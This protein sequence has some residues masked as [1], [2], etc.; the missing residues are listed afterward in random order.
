M[1]PTALIL[2]AL[3]LAGCLDPDGAGNL[4]PKTVVEDPTLPRV[5]IAGALLHAE[6]F[7]PANAPTVIALHGGPGADYASLMPLKA[8]ADVDGFH[9][10]FW[11]QRGCGL[12]QRFD[13]DT[14][15]VAAYMEDL[16]LVVE[17]TV[18][19]GAPFVFIG[20]S[21]GGMYA[22]AFINDHGDYN[23]RLR[24]A[25]LSEPGAFT[26]QQLEDFISRFFTTDQLTSELVNDATWSGQFLS[27]DDHARAD[28]LAAQMTLRGAPAEHRNLKNPPPF[29]RLGAVVATR[30]PELALEQ[31]F[32][33]TTHLSAFTPKVLFLRGE[34]NEA[35]PLWHQ[36]QLAASYPN[37][38]VITIG[39]AGHEL[40]WEQPGEYLAHV[41]TY[42][43]E[44]GFMSGS[45]GGVQ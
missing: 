12:S 22:T 42:F 16:R 35:A 39:G 13:R 24:G 26:K 27:P 8:L 44:I 29:W 2:S 28:Y 34:L 1:K 4:V 30:L 25:V 43:T 20:H 31:G 17:K 32:D 6:S 37:A 9:V 19:P 10:V 18:A 11:D 45:S 33:W 36:Q 15:S 41:R 7:G 14:Y 21:W 38:E 40:I 5:E 3:A 23:G